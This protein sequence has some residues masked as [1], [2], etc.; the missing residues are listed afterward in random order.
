ML[1]VEFCRSMCFE[2]LQFCSAE[3]SLVL[4][5]HVLSNFQNRML[6]VM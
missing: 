6:H 3:K 1:R 5:A 2:V 4:T